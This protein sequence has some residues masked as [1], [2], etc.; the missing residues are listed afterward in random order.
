MNISAPPP[1]EKRRVVRQA[2]KKKRGCGGN[3][4][5]PACSAAR[6]AAVGWEAARPCVSKEAKPAKVVSLIVPPSI[7]L[8]HRSSNKKTDKN[9]LQDNINSNGLR[10]RDCAPLKKCFNFCGLCLPPSGGGE[11]LG[12]F[13]QRNPA[14][15]AQR[16]F[17]LRPRSTAIFQN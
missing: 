15:F 4:F 1:A 11:P 17:E 2:G 12:G 7:L 13:N 3:E 16:L 10:G 9:F 6:S 14:D 8:K 5:L